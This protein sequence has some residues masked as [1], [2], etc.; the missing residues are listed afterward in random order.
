MKSEEFYEILGE[1]REDYV[2]EAE[3]QKPRPRARQ[4]A[5]ACRPACALPR[6]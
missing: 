2:E 1:I 5:R 6:R 3:H 4:M